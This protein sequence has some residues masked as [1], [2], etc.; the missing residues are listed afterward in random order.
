[1]S[2]SLHD[3]TLTHGDS[4]DNACPS[5]NNGFRQLV[6]HSHPGAR[7]TFESLQLDQAMS[8]TSLM[9]QPSKRVR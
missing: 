1:M 7:T 5:W 9:Q 8:V 6:G 4:T 3:A 2:V